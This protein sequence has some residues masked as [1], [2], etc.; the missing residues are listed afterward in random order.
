[1]IAKIIKISTS[2]VY[3]SG[4]VWLAIHTEVDPG[5]LFAPRLFKYINW[6]FVLYLWWVLYV[7]SLNTK[8]RYEIR[9][10]GTIA[11]LAE[12]ISC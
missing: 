3:L 9:V 2:V 11:P 5:G 1:L 6:A 7:V 4:Q 12:T 8:V 10:T